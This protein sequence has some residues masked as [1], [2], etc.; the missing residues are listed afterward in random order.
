MAPEKRFLRKIPNSD[1]N[2]I[3]PIL[4]PTLEP[5]PN[6]EHHHRYDH[7]P[8]RTHHPRP[9]QEHTRVLPSSL[10]NR[11]GSRCDKDQGQTMIPR[12]HTPSRKLKQSNGANPP[13]ARTSDHPNQPK[14]RHPNKSPQHP[15]N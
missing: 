14:T 8:Q 11:Q 3:A 4:P 13:T 12:H 1:E 5:H 6:P 2:A 7:A 10:R 9:H 15:L